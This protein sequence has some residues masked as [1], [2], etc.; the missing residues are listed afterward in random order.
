MTF[1]SFLA[2]A[3]MLLSIVFGMLVI[4]RER[5]WR[6]LVIVLLLAVATMF[7]FWHLLADV[8][9]VTHPA[10][11]SWIVELARMAL[12]V[13]AVCSVWVIR[14]VI[15]ARKDAAMDLAKSEEKFQRAFEASPD[16]IVI[17]RMS[18]SVIL[19]VNEG[20]QRLSGL[21]RERA[22]GRTSPELGV[23]ADLEDRNRLFEALRRGGR[24]RNMEFEFLDTDGVAHLC[25]I[26]AETFELAGVP[27]AV[28]IARDITEKRRLEREIDLAAEQER[29]RIGTDLH[30]SLA[31]EL[32]GISMLL[33]A[34][35][36]SGTSGTQY[37]EIEQA[38]KG[39]IGTVRRFA[40]GLAP[41]GL[42]NDGLAGALR[43]L[44]RAI[45]D[46]YGVEFHM[47]IPAQVTSGSTT[48]DSHL[49]W[50]AQEAMYNAARHGQC[51]RVWVSLE[52]DEYQ[53]VLT[54]RDNGRGISAPADKDAVGMGM[55]T[56][57]HRAQLTGS[58]LE[59]LPLPDGGTEVRCRTP[60][61]RS[62]DNGLERD[63]GPDGKR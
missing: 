23:W 53:L 19:D 6:L 38:L 30:D 63:A 12:A 56:M 29:R 37:Q 27:H 49:Y 62:R 8:G 47:Q 59:V 28:T 15:A 61:R 51:T 40:R 43:S 44:S 7:E 2:I 32:V 5:E 50:I 52:G 42:E 54:V 48:T 14:G 36:Q 11:D 13:L 1:I 16:A 3:I 46:M 21:P 34:Y 9:A 39:A 26:S 35:H 18:D 25:E 4:R 22:V 17:T 31:Q 20:F 10:L 58:E 55:K 41:L 33:K 60:L 45:G 57:N 24:A